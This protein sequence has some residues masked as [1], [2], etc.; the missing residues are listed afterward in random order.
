[1]NG[2]VTVTKAP[3]SIT[4]SNGAMTY[5]GTVSH[6]HAELFGLRQRRQRGIADHGTDLLDRGD[7]LELRD[8]LA[9]PSSCSGAVDSNYA[10][11]YPTGAVTV[12]KAPL[13]VTASSQQPPMG[14]CQ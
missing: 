13:A 3:L 5:G 2:S 7:E 10:I 11:T 9:L 1:V 4:A 8:R 14:P 6:H 12:A